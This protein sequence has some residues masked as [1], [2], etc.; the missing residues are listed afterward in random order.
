MF[1]KINKKIIISYI[2]IFLA[3]LFFTKYVWTNFVEIKNIEFVFKPVFLFISF[4]LWCISYSG[5]SFIWRRILIS[6]D[7]NI[8]IS[9]TSSFKMY[10]LTEFSKYIP[11]SVWSVFARTYFSNKLNTQ[12][13][14]IL[15]A[16][17]IDAILAAITILA[18]G[19]FFLILHFSTT[20]LFLIL[21]ASGISI[22]GFILLHPKI[23]YFVSNFVLEKMGREKIHLD[24][25][26]SY[27]KIIYFSLQKQKKDFYSWGF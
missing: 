14:H 24:F 27:K 17:A 7:K 4:F 9:K 26:L 20:H 8:T 12:K 3:I 25:M 6:I 15:T 16:S 2:F 23:F 19:S 5:Y 18:L 13:R 21:I 10:I 1:Y 11:G 22:F